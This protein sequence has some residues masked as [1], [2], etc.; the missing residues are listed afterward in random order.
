MREL[1]TPLA[2]DKFL[3]PFHGSMQARRQLLAFIQRHIDRAWQE[4]QA[5]SSSSSGG[6]SGS[7]AV[8]ARN[9][10]LLYTLLVMCSTNKE[11]E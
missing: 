9:K 10:P 3:F 1:F 7:K 6:S 5:D 2:V 8:A 4:M 11:G